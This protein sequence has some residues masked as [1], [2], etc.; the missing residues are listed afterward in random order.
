[1]KKLP[2]PRCPRCKELLVWQFYGMKC[3]FCDYV[4]YHKKRKNT[5]KKGI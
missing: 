5:T 4:E 2:K 3:A 1:M